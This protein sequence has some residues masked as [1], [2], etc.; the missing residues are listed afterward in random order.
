M[1]RLVISTVGT[2]ILTNQ[3][4]M[5]SES[6]WLDL[7]EDRAND[8]KLDGE[9]ILEA[10]EE[11]TC[12]A[13]AKLYSDPKQK[14]LN[15]DIDEIRGA[16]AELNGIYGLYCDGLSQGKQDIHWL[17]T[18]DTAQGQVSAEIIRDFLRENHL[19]VDIHTPKD[20]STASTENFTN[21]IDELL[22]WFDE[23]IPGY[24]DS[25]YHICFNLVGGFKAL[26]G[27]ANTIGM[28]Y[29][30]E[31]IYIFEG[32]SKKEG[33]IKIPRLPIQ[34]DLSVIKPVQFALMAA[35]GWVNLSELEDVPETLIFKVDDTA[36]LTTWGR[37]IWNRSK[38]DL[39]SG[40]LLQFPHI[41]YESSFKRDYD[42]IT[43]KN[44]R[45]KLQETLSEVSY[46]LQESQGDTSVLVNTGLKYDPYQGTKGIDHFRV[47]LS[48][49]VSCKVIA[50]DLFLRYYGTHN[51]VQRSEGIK[52]K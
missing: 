48:L 38:K 47:N 52:G 35:G 34:V 31:I 1:P 25:G 22:K 44:E 46:K 39:L 36:T 13:K 51:H 15:D 17:I 16:S 29:A 37:L 28:F 45:L 2:S 20:L 4:N 7:L 27:Y 43:D 10:I 24:Q 49:R 12:R 26:Q 30:N 5:R 33:I 18:T 3:I 50:K 11:L 41:K 19:V 23:I 9:D 42:N 32:S 14:I 21:G 8:K 40:E 6:D